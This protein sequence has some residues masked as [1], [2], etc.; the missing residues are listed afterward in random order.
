MTQTVVTPNPTKKQTNKKKN[1]KKNTHTHRP[2]EACFA[3]VTIVDGRRN[4]IV[5]ISTPN[6]ATDDFYGYTITKLYF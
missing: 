6:L 5:N 3:C 1:H 4:L 2:P